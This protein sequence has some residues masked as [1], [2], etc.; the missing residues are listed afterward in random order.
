MNIF[1]VES[2]KWLPTL[3]S[4]EVVKNS[5]NPNPRLSLIPYHWGVQLALETFT[6]TWSLASDRL[7][8]LVE[9]SF[10]TGQICLIVVKLMSR[11]MEYYVNDDCLK[12]LVEKW[13]KFYL[14]F[15]LVVISQTI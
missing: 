14:K 5:R 11:T 13:T 12:F 1:A 10:F 2:R 7:N 15:V 3:E 9:S 8:L 4:P 6:L